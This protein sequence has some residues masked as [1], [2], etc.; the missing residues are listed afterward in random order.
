MRPGRVSS[1]T[2]DFYQANLRLRD[3]Q[4]T[5]ALQET[6]LALQATAT[7][8]GDARGAAAAARKGATIAKGIGVK[9][10]YIPDAPPYWEE[11]VVVFAGETLTRAAA[12]RRLREAGH[13]PRT[14]LRV[15]DSAPPAA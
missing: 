15:L 10:G 9:F 2:L 3:I 13:T 8:G 4:A 1:G 7:A 11:R 5:L 12:H 14:A 6:G